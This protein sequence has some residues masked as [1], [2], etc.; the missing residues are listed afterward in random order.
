MCLLSCVCVGCYALNARGMVAHH[1]FVF[2]L[3]FCQEKLIHKH[4]QCFDESLMILHYRFGQF[5]EIC[6]FVSSLGFLEWCIPVFNGRP[7][8]FYSHFLL[9]YKEKWFFCCF[10]LLLVEFL[11]SQQEQP[12]QPNRGDGSFFSFGRRGGV[13]VCVSGVHVGSRED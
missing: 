8:T 3:Y 4:V 13:H 12:K 5:A 11:E 9:D 7:K 6:C 1:A 10:F 2:F